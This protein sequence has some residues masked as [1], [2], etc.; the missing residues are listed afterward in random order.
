MGLFNYKA[1]NPEGRI[2]RGHLEALNPMDLEMRLKRMDLDLVRAAPRHRKTLFGG[3]VPRRELINFCFYLEQLNRAGVPILEG[4]ADLGESVPHPR[5]REVLA[6]LRESIAGGL[7]LS[8]ALAEHPSVFSQVFVSLVRAG[9]LSGQLPEVLA[10]L[11]DSLKWEDELSSQIHKVI[12]Y[13]AFV[14]TIVTGATLFLMFYLV[15]QLRQF[16]RNTGQELP[17]QTQALFFTSD[18]LLNNWHAALL[19]LISSAISLNILLRRNPLLRRRF[20]G[21]KLG[22]P[23]LGPI[24][25]KIALA[26]FA[27]TFAL[28]YA[29][30]ISVLESIRTTQGVV[31]NRVIRRGLE[32]VEQ[33]IGEGQ[34]VTAAFQNIGLFPPL[35]I[36]MLRVGESTGELDQAL[37][38]VSYFFNRDVKESA[39][40]LQS[41]IE[42]MLTVIL[43][44]LLGWIMLAVLGPVYE[45]I[46]KLKT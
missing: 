21:F 20:D 35:V 46:S 34:N 3:S 33:S 15:P 10:N 39:E 27:N 2:V 44:C 17:L 4:L 1:V 30:G 22:L 11:S 31:G 26:R 9:E 43:G 13:P 7:T 5:F 18:L 40:K 28:L 19:L 25:K 38:N 6:G 14:G 16:V 8:Q 23:I 42:P 24:L 45:V 29:S 12:L 37:R 41:L 32:E 36:R